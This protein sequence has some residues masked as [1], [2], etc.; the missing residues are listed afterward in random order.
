MQKQKNI[1]K[2]FCDK[3]DDFVEYNIESVKESR[4]ILNQEEIEIDAKVAVCK[5]CKTKLFHE[6]LDREN[7]KRAFDK[8]KEKKNIL[9]VQEIKYIRKK[10]NLTQKEISRLLG[11]GE[12]TYHRYENGSLPD[13]THNNQLRLIKNPAN[14]KVLLGNNSDN[15]S[16]KTVK[17]LTKRLEELLDNKNKVEVNLPEKL[18]RH[19]KL[20][21][22]KDQMSIS[23]YLLFLITKEDAA[24]KAEKEKQKLKK[25][26][27]ISNLRYKTSPA[28]VWNQKSISE[29]KIKY[30]I[31]NKKAKLKSF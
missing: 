26:I 24:D 1:D 11:W 16:S 18:Y 31:K 10:Y 6:Q 25:D 2:L 15:L 28:A 27:Q 4:N 7:Q 22:Q 19:I 20:K 21:A 12:I 9:P 29:E 17:K 14:V 3:C 13:Q 5:N 30:K 8:F 23:E